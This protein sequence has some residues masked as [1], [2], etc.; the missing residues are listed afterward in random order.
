M[1]ECCGFCPG[2]LFNLI[3]GYIIIQ[4]LRTLKN[5]LQRSKSNQ[6]KYIVLTGCDSGFGYK[7][8]LKLSG[9]NNYILAGCL[10]SEGV[11]R[12]QMDDTFTGKAFLL[13]VTKDEDIEKMV[14][15]VREEIDDQ[16]L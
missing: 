8:A 9:A 16:G 13:D 14:S 6:T 7:T 12:L 5:F 15:M 11:H 1:G 2:W 10:T 4:M 3:A